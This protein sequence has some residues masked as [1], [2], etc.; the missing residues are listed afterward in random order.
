MSS[1]LSKK[2]K[3]R[4]KKQFWCDQKVEDQEYCI[5]EMC[6]K[7]HQGLYM[8]FVDFESKGLYA[9]I[10]EAAIKQQI[11]RNEIPEISVY[12]QQIITQY[13]VCIQGWYKKMLKD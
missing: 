11:R 10:V 1:I 7:K 2:R 12:I 13:C 9:S 6:Y 8:S 4:P 5:F 3:M